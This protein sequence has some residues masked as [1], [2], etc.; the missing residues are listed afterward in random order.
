MRNDY[1]AAVSENVCV[2]LPISRE[3]KLVSSLS[4]KAAQREHKEPLSSKKWWQMVFLPKKEDC[5]ESFQFHP[6]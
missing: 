2:Q 6:V 4:L 5:L 3:G 1:Q